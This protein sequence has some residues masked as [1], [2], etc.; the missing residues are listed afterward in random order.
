MAV[1]SMYWLFSH[2]NTTGAF[3]TTARLSASWNEPMFVVPSPKK[4]T[5]TWPEPRYCADQAAPTAIGRCAPTIAYEPIAPC[6]TLVR[7]IEPP[8][9]PMSAPC[10]PTSSSSIGVIGTPRAR[11]WLWPRYVQKV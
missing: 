5:A 7:C 1:Y 3:Q 6:S 2:T 4:Q 8:L 9:P 11:V 10:L